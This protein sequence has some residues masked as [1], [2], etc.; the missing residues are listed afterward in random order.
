MNIKKFKIDYSPVE[1]KIVFD[2]DADGVTCNGSV[3]VNDGPSGTP[4][5]TGEG[6]LD[7]LYRV[8]EGCQKLRR[9]II[10]KIDEQEAIRHEGK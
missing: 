5:P 3:D 1:G 7:L 9:S 6:L 10:K 4:V 2:I 8:E